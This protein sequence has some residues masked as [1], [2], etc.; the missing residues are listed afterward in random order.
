MKFNRLK[1]KIASSFVLTGIMTF[2]LIHLPES[3]AFQLT[4]QFCGN[5][6]DGSSGSLLND[7][8]LKSRVTLGVKDDGTLDTDV[9]QN[10]LISADISTIVG[11]SIL[12]YTEIDLFSSAPVAVAASSGGLAFASTEDATAAIANGSAY[13][14][15]GGPSSF[16]MFE[17]QNGSL[18]NFAIPTSLNL[19]SVQPFST[20]DIAEVR[21][22]TITWVRS[23]DVPKPVPEPVSLLAG[24]TSLG[25]I[26]LMR[27]RMKR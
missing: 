3:H 20:V 24:I 22:G 16:W 12:D 17:N 13:A 18:F 26:N 15:L 14:F 19:K 7:Q 1:R 5:F 21:T 11:G 25:F 9:G 6:I 8:V 2:G 27:R 23:T 10:G 4:L